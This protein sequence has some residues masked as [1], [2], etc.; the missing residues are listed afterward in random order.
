MKNILRSGFEWMKNVAGNAAIDPT[1]ELATVPSSSTLH[2]ISSSVAV[3]VSAGE[4]AEQAVYTEL[5]VTNGD[6]MA[7]TS[8][9]PSTFEK[10][11]GSVI[12]IG[13]FAGSVSPLDA[14][15]AE[16]FGEGEVVTEESVTTSADVVEIVADKSDDKG[17]A[18][19]VTIQA[20]AG[21]AYATCPHCQGMFNIRERLVDPRTMR[22]NLLKEL[23]CPACEKHVTLPENIDARLL[24]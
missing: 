11:L 17:P 6:E 5:K 24:R 8:G 3:E 15:L 19:P 10:E 23:D 1:S 4:V 2:E 12:D 9:G 21:R 22:V 7:P 18:L 20:R 16:E 13:S 14:A